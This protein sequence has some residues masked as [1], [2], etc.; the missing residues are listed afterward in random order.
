MSTSQWRSIA[1]TARQIA[2]DGIRRHRGTILL[3][4]L[5][6][7]LTLKIS[8]HLFFGIDAT[9]RTNDSN[10]RF[11]AAEINRIW[12]ASKQQ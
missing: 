5:V 1:K 9:T 2:I 7:T 12:L 10:I 3:S 8:L 4:P 6:Q 11:I